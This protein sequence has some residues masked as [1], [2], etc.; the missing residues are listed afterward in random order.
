MVKKIAE[1]IPNANY[2]RID[3]KE[4]KTS[5]DI[6]K[7]IGTTQGYVGYNDEHLFTKLKNNNF[8][9]ILFDNYKEA[10]QNVKGLIKEILKEG[11]IT[12]NKGDKIYFTNTFI[13]ITND[14][15]PT[16]NVGF[17]NQNKS[18]EDN[19]LD[20]LVDEKIVFKDLTKDVLESYLKTKNVPDIDRII[21]KSNY[22]KNNYQD[23]AKLIKEEELMQI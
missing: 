14:T 15:V 2:I 1:G 3:L 7:L 22:E 5:I 6:N 8:S 13:F 19:E 17:N 20:D 23:I 18:E 16:H 12:D 9:V 4:F 21:A 10:H 11:Y